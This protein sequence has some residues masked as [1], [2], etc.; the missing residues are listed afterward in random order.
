MLSEIAAGYGIALETIMNANGISDANLIFVGQTV[1]IPDCGHSAEPAAEPIT[2]Q[3]VVDE[4][5]AAPAP[6]E[7]ATQ[8]IHVVAPGDTLGAISQHYG[9]DLAEVVKL[10]AI[11]NPSLIVVGQQIMIP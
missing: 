7:T 10:N 3:P 5:E 6:E 1:Q 9:V 2:T 11:A 4:T 8:T